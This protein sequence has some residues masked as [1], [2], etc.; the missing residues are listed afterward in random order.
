MIRVSTAGATPAKLPIIVVLSIMLHGPTLVL[1]QDTAGGS[2]P[3]TDA[4]QDQL[5]DQKQ[6]I[7]Q[8]ESAQKS[9]DDSA[10]ALQKQLDQQ[11]KQ[12]EQAQSAIGA[13]TTAQTAS[14]ASIDDLQKTLTEQKNQLDAQANQLKKQEQEIVQAQ[15]FIN[16]QTTALQSLQTQVDR[17]AQAMDQEKEPTQDEVAMKERLANLETQVSGIPVD[18]A[19]EMGG[20]GFPGSLR[21]PGTNAAYRAG[22]YVKFN[23]VSSFD[24]IQSKDRFIVGSIPVENAQSAEVGANTSLTA[25]QTRINFDLREQSSVGQFRAFVEGDFAGVGDTFRL[26]HAYGQFRYFLTGKTWSAFYDAQANMEE[27]D[28]EGVNGQTVLRQAQMRYFPEIGENI[29][30]AFSLE[31]PVTEATDYDF[32]NVGVNPADFSAQ[33]TSSSELPD[34]VASIRR[35]WFG[36]WHLKTAI[37]LRKLAAQSVFTPGV[38]PST[39]AW[40]LS[41][42]GVFKIPFWGEQDNIKFQL[43]GGRGVGRYLNDTNTL[44]GLDA[45]FAPDGTLDALPIFGGYAAFQHFWNEQM[46]STFLYS[47]V[48]IDNYD[49]QPGNSY[50]KTDRFSGNFVWSPIRRVDIGAELIWGRRTNRDNKDASALQFQLATMYKF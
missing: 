23:Y 28:F 14:G 21:V 11:Q 7:G 6:Q 2:G 27:L 33:A 10:Q 47:L 34:L 29:D 35:N 50:K 31:D 22:G 24:P 18:P 16:T 45:V 4:L 3:S 39:T 46:R 40:G 20:K 1:A 12:L 38:D 8:Q 49:Y 37:V 32:N 36:R 43:M 41:A 13:Q 19:T 26:R 9:A 30:L 44:G 5:D 17:L 15:N 25:N 48:K 42:S